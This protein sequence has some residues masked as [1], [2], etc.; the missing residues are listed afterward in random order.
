[1]SNDL[2][3]T[4][5][6]GAPNA[7]SVSPAQ[8]RALRDAGLNDDQVAA[9]LDVSRDAISLADAKA[10]VASGRLEDAMFNPAQMDMVKTVLMKELAL[11]DSSAA[12]LRAAALI[13]EY[14]AIKHETRFKAAAG[15]DKAAV[16]NN[17]MIAVNSAKDKAGR[18]NSGS[19]QNV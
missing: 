9:A 4:E 5:N 2:Q 14:G 3:L 1:M 16:T 11:G 6:P 7:I 18:H 12:R 15:M 8:V 17:I 19:L 10:A 13:L